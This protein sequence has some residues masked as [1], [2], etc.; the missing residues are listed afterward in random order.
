KVGTDNNYYFIATIKGNNN[1]QLNGQPQTVYNVP[2]G[3]EDIFLF[4]TTCDGQ[5]RWSQAIGGEHSDRAYNLVLDSN[6][7]VYVGAY[8]TGGSSYNIHFSPNTAHDITPFPANMDAHKRI[9]LVKYDNNGVFQGKKALQGT[10]NGSIDREAVIL[11][12]VIDSQNKLH[13]IVGLLNGTHLDNQVTVP[14]QYVYEPSTGIRHFQY[15]LVQYDTNLDYLNSMVLPIEPTSLFEF[16]TTRFAYDETLNQYYI[17]GMRSIENS[18]PVPLTYN[19]APF[20]ERSYILAFYGVNSTTGVD[21]D[22]V[23]RR[24]IYS[25]NGDNLFTS[26]KIDSN[27]DVYFGGR[28][29][30]NQNEHNLKVYDPTDTS[31]Q[32]YTFT[33]VPDTNLP[34][35]VKFNSSG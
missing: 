31:I 13:F 24:E 35:V 1:T 8:V 11:D 5:V 4:S 16:G 34:T 33:P 23:W 10:V 9:Y 26:I 25:D 14:S 22:E 3:G 19:G 18:P 29:W 17:A 28:I 20:V 27:S 21:G 32:A 6:N 12:L 30:K 15:L 7:N 2:N